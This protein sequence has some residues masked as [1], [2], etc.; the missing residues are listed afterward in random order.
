MLMRLPGFLLV[1]HRSEMLA[2][3]S[4]KRRKLV[5]GSLFG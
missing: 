2:D 3:R 4:S 5:D 1:G